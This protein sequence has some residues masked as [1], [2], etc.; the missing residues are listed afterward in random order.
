MKPILAESEFNRVRQCRHGLMLYN[1]NDVYVGGS[2]E[3]YGEFS[4]GEVEMFRTIV[5]PG[6]KVIEVGAN[7]GSH[8]VFLAR[9]VGP[10]GQVI[11]F[12]PQRIVFQTLCANIALNS[13]RNVLAYPMAVA[14]EP[15]F[16][17][18]PELDPTREIN[19][20]GLSIEGHQQ[21]CTT[22]QVTLDQLNEPDVKLIKIDVEGMELKVLKGAGETIK[23]CRPLLY[24]EN[25]RAEKAAELISHLRG[26]NYDLYEHLPPLFSP[27]NFYRNTENIFGEIV[28]ENLLCVPSE[29]RWT[30]PGLVKR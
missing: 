16:V 11:A 26:L 15:G 4:E 22:R 20:G 19:F 1:K 28:S 25:D 21:G 12:E 14:D 2:F 27:G 13:F 3:R 8:T 29:K 17:K 5:G 24:L 10:T 18:I 9:Q 7:I 6:H 30:P 23:R